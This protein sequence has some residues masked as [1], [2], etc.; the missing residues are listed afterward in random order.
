MMNRPK[1]DDYKISEYEYSG[2]YVI[3]LENY[4]DELEEWLIFTKSV[5]EVNQESADKAE[6]L[7]VENEK[8]NKAL[9]KACEMLE[10]IGRI[11]SRVKPLNKE[12][13]KERLMNNEKTTK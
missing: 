13:W 4:C 7:E 8:L 5:A 12:Q 2:T 1:R 10:L 3:D 9:D 6:I 11:S